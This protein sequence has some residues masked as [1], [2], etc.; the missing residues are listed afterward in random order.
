MKGTIRKMSKNKEQCLNIISQKFNNL[1][2]TKSQKELS[3]ILE[4]SIKEISGAEYGFLLKVDSKND[5]LDLKLSNSILKST[6]A[7]KKPLFENHI[8]SHK[9]YNQKV[10]N[11]L[12]IEIK[13]MLIIPILNQEETTVIGFIQ[14]INSVKNSV[15]FGRYDLRILSLLEPIARNI[16]EH[17]DK[18]AIAKEENLS[19]ISSTPIKRKTKAN[20]EL[21]LQQYEEKVQALKA[22][23]KSKEI[24]IVDETTLILNF[25]TNE[26]L[27]F[28]NER[29][30][31]YLFLEII[32]NSLHNPK[33]LALIDESLEDSLFINNLT[34]ELYTIEKLPLKPKHFHTIQTISSVVNLYA[35]E[36]SNRDITFNI[37]IEPQIPNWLIGDVNKIKSLMVHLLNNLYGLIENGGAIE[38]LV[39]FSTQESSL[40][41]ELKGL[42]PHKTKEIKKFFKNKKVSHSLTTNDNG[43][44]L[45]ICSSLINILGAKLKLATRGGEEHIFKINIPLIIKPN[46]IE[47]SCLYK[48]PMKIGILMNESNLYAYQNIERYLLSFGIEKKNIFHFENLKKINSTTFFHLICFENMLTEEFNISRFNSIVILKYNSEQSSNIYEE[49]IEVNELYINSYYGMVLQKILFP[50]SPVEITAPRTLLIKESFLTKVINKLKF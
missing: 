2:N 47:K 32:K 3:Q 8:I 44:G 17:K 36:F 34:Q 33:Q 27:Y 25:L 30:H 9:E 42:L 37:F 49:E 20:L 14:A 19:I 7:S 12:N 11:P 31:I 23:L 40:D 39:S 5:A 29:H 13:S 24:N 43:L 45:S 46:Q 48:I 15:E 38:V 22:E 6:L 16:L 28:A 18:E 35:H 41:I 10:D 26:S 4:E 1:E 50:K 21:E